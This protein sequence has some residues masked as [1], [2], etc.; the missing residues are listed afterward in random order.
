MMEKKVAKRNRT[1]KLAI[2]SL[3]S[4]NLMT[5]S[6]NFSPSAIQAVRNPSTG[7]AARFDHAVMGGATRDGSVVLSRHA[8]KPGDVHGRGAHLSASRA[9]R[10]SC[11]HRGHAHEGTHRN[12]RHVMVGGPAT[13]KVGGHA[14][15][16]R[17]SRASC[18][19]TPDL[20]LA[21]RLANDHSSYVFLA[22]STAP[23]PSAPLWTMA[24]RT[25]RTGAAV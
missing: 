16:S 23:A 21:V 10:S 17:S 13:S 2:E 12:K 20:S 7:T 24:S 25:H 1:V 4:R 9:S 22:A 18:I 3:E 11:H 19:S 5:V 8:V 14:K 15:K 6:P